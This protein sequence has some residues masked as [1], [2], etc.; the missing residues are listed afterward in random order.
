MFSD[1]VFASTLSKRGNECAQVHATDFGWVR[2]H[3]VA[4]KH[5]AHETLFLLLA[6]ESLRTYCICNNTKEMI[7]DKFKEKL[8][9]A[10]CQL[11]QFKSY[12]FL[13]NT[14][15]RETKGLKKG[16]SYE[17]IWS[18]AP[19]HVCDDCLELKVYIR[20][21]SVHGIPK[22]WCHDRHQATV[23]SAN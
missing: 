9:D 5:W 8:K 19:K 10:A 18:R 2:V 14:A 3:P 23:S 15:E 17:L 12:T 6:R 21:N 4:S 11:K 13:S 16:A 20:L 7:Q 22:Q 1:K